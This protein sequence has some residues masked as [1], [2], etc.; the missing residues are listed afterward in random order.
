MDRHFREVETL[1]NVR[2]MSDADV[3]ENNEALRRGA[4][5]LGWRAGLLSHNRDGCRRSGFCELGCA[6]DGK[7]NARKTVI[8][9]AV[10]HGARVRANTRVDRVRIENGRA[11]GIEAT[12]VRTGRT[13]TVRARAVVL[14]GSAVGSAVLALRS[15][16]PDPHG[17]IGRG[18]HIHPGGVVAGIFD[19]E[20]AGW[21]GIPQS[22]ECTEW[23]DF[24]R[25][26]A[27]RVWLVPA[28]AHPV[29]SA[30]MLPGVG[31]DWTG[32]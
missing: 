4:N 27:R 20:I 14:A 17:R 8:P 26:S 21:R 9:D 1:L 16:V 31:P 7:N 18:L 5:A 30:A 28:F 2:S 15:A 3:N 13:V 10:A 11:V 29:G 32:G 22:I 23:L 6:Y 12:D 25:D 19:R 24:A